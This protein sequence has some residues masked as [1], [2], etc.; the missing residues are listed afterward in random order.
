M[1]ASGLL[2]KIGTYLSE[3]SKQDGEAYSTITDRASRDAALP[4]GVFSGQGKPF[5]TSTGCENDCIGGTGLLVFLSFE[6]ILER[7][8]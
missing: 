4:V 3:N 1:T 7:S 2:R 8:L 6:P 5:C